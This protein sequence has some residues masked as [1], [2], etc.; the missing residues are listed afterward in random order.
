M[1][2]NFL[3]V[4]SKDAIK[5]AIA[6]NDNDH[7]YDILVQPLHE[8][9]YRRKTFD[10]LDELS[11]GQQLLLTFDYLRTQVGQGG[12]IQFIH[13]GYIALLPSMIEQLYS[14][15]CGDMALTLDDVLKVY[16]LNRELFNKA[17]TVQEFAQLYD[18][19][20]EF[21]VLEE[22]YNKI[23]I[24]TMRHMLEYAEAHLDEFVVAN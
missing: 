13:N 8:E 3:P 20:K 15:G 5:N 10:F 23:K 18:E 14:I 7:V 21:E 4:V 16:V 17:T 24:T 2:S 22:R 1:S 11:Q 6:E 19:L 12:F 9:L